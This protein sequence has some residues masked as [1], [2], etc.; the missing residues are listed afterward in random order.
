[1]PLSTIDPRTALVVVDL[2]NGATLR[3]A[4]PNPITE[5]IGRTAELAEAFRARD[6]PVVLVR[7]TAAPGD[8]DA[9][10]GRSDLSGRGGG[11]TPPPGWDELVPELAGHPGDLVVD[12]KNWGSFQGTDLDQRLRRRGVTQLVLTGVATSFG[13]ESTA[14][15]AHELGYNL[16]VPLDAVTDIDATAH[17]HTAG[18]ILPIL[19]ETGTTAELLDLLQASFPL[20]G[21]PGS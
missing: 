16:T 6:L 21:V 13:V 1:M 8:P 17:A 12:K 15:A 14:R 18:R 5:V 2:Q 11:G 10:P 19:A 9:A 7:F 20:A 3:P 4:A